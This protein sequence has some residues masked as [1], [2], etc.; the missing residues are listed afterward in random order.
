[1]M[2]VAA[3]KYFTKIQKQGIL[4]LPKLRTNN[5]VNVV[6]QAVDIVPMI[7]KM[8]VIRQYI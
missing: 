3:V 1:M 6:D 7:I 2:H 4:Y 8:F 5:V